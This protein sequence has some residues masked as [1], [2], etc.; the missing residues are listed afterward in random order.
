M[1]SGKQIEKTTIRGAQYTTAASDG[2]LSFSAATAA[3]VVFCIDDYNAVAGFLLMAFAAGIGTVRFYQTCPSVA[4]VSLHL[5]AAWSVQVL[6]LPLLAAAYLQHYYPQVSFLLPAASVAVVLLERYLFNVDMRSIIAEIFGAVAVITVLACNIFALNLFGI[7]GAATI[8][9]A[10]LVVK[11]EG[12][13]CG[14]L[15]VDIFHYM[16]AF[17]NVA[18]LKGL[19]Q[20]QS[21]P[22]Y[23]KPYYT[24]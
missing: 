1:Q 16:V 5:Y 23:Y 15:C 4:L 6:G 22:S 3:A 13:I 19:Q 17:S 7:V 2:I 18:L 11:T 9:V 8:A 14:Y 24:Q 21:A 20:F 12:Q 10:G